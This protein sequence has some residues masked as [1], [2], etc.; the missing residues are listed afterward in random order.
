MKQRAQSISKR[1]KGALSAPVHT[2]QKLIV[3]A[4]GRNAVSCQETQ[5]VKLDIIAFYMALI[6]AT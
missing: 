2:T 5:N 1:F 6:P 3:T 4:R